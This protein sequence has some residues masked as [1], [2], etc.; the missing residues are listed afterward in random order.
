M[1]DEIARKFKLEDSKF[2]GYCEPS[3]FSDWLAECY[4]DWYRFPSVARFLFARRKRI[5]SA[6]SY[7]SSVERDCERCK[8]VIKS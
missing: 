5:G 3:V 2:D 6:N 4:F 1:K 7:W 8:V